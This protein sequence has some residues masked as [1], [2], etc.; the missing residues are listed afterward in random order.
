MTIGID[1]GMRMPSEP[2]VVMTPAPNLFGNPCRTM[3]GRR[4]EPIATTVAGLEPDTAAN[5]AQAITPASAR[6][7]YQWPTM[8]VAKVIMR[9]ATPPWVRKLPARMKNGIAMISK[10]SMPV[11]S[12]KATASSGTWV[13]VNRNVSTLRPRAIDTGMPVTISANSSAKINVP[14]AAGPRSTSPYLAAK[15]SATRATGT[16]MRR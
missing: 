5:S 16:T 10:L 8:V 7:P 2:E 1:G 4:M 9:R 3:A 12:F 14:R 15:Q 13:S 11:K 6:P